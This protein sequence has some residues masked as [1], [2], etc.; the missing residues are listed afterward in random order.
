MGTTANY[1][2]PYPASTDAPDVPADMKDLA[3]AIDL[4]VDSIDDRCDGYEAAWTAYTPTWTG[5]TTNPALGNGTIVGA[6]MKVGKTVTVNI[7]LKTGSTTT[8]GSGAWEFSIPFTG[9]T[10]TGFSGFPVRLGVWAGRDA[11]ASTYYDGRAVVTSGNTT[12]GTVNPA[13]SSTGPFTWASGD[14]LGIQITYE[15]V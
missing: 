10:V 15:A 7:L 3:D 14:Y 5:A 9:I 2:W 12:V 8:Y 1:S 11:S 13:L 4:T 6:Y